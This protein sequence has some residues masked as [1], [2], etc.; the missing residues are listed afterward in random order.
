[1]KILE[2]RKVFKEVEEIIDSYDVCDKCNLRISIDLYETFESELKIKFG[3]DCPEGGD[4]DIKSMNLC[5][6][7]SLEL[8]ELLKNN[9]YRINESG[10][11]W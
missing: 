8:L 1:M 3:T 5:Q 6:N 10:W 9:N 11:S 7:C 4:G 2:K